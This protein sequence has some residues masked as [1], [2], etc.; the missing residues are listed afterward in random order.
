MNKEFHKGNRERLYRMMKPHSLIVLF[1]GKEKTKTNDEYY[2]FYANRSF[3]Y[4]T[5]LE[6]KEFVLVAKKEDEAVTEMVFVLPSDPLAERWTGRRLTKEEVAEK[7]G[8]EQIY[9][10]TMFES[11]FHRMALSGNYENLYLDLYKA[12]ADGDETPA[13]AFAR[14]AAKTYAYLNVKNANELISV[15]RTIKQPCEIE[16]MRK[17]EEITK[18]GITAMM[19]ASKPGMYEYQ[20]KAEFDHALG[21]FGPQGP[22]FPSIISAGQNNFC[23]SINKTK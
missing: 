3:V 7:S 6:S 20:Y 4:L 21:Q 16:A 5:G 2:P 17:A 10:N 14:E 11:M 15:L 12:A 23:I 19:K 18:A 8:I 1:S 22:A 9:P 13:F